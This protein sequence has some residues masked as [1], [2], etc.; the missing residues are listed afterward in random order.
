VFVH[1]HPA[2][3]GESLPGEPGVPKGPNGTG[4]TWALAISPSGQPWAH[5]GLRLAAMRG[6]TANLGAGVAMDWNLVFDLWPDSP[7]VPD[8]DDV[9]SMAFCPDGALWVGSRTHGLARVDTATGALS[10]LALPGGGQEV[11]ALACDRRGQLWISTD[12]GEIVR[13]DTRAGA[14]SMA[15]AGLPE[16]ARHVAWNIQV[17]D[18]AQPQPVI[19]FAMRQLRGAP[20]GVVSYSGP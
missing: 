1:E 2:F 17:D 8:D 4:E 7:T 20:G 12:W 14:F 19:Y 16:L 5:D 3:N 11:W 15:P 10:G 18:A 6:D 9:Q 13:Y